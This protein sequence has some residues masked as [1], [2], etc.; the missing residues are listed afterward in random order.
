MTV[1]HLGDVE[2]ADGEGFGL[3]FFVVEDLGARG[4]PVRSA[5]TAG[6]GLTIAS[7]G[8]I[9]PRSSLSST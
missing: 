8:S 6:A 7:T 3:G 2:F 1:D 9:R 5:N 4:E